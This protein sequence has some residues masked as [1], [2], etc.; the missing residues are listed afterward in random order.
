[1][2]ATKPRKQR[3]S[4]MSTLTRL[5]MQRRA[6]TRRITGVIWRAFSASVALIEFGLIASVSVACGVIYHAYAYEGPGEVLAYLTIGS[7]VALIFV[8]TNAFRGDYNI[9]EYI[10]GSSRVRRPFASWNIAFLY[11]LALSFAAKVGAEFSRGNVILLY[12]TGILTLVLWRAWLTRLVVFA[13]K[14]GQ[15]AARRVLLVG[16]RGAI[17]EFARRYQPWNLGFEIVGEAVLQ[18][19]QTF[20]RDLERAASIGRALHPD[21]VFILMPWSMTEMIERVVDKLLTVPVSIHLGPERIL[22][23]FARVEIVKV[24]SMATMCLVQPPLSGI[25]ILTKRAFDF[26]ASVVGLL[27]L[28]PLFAVVALAVKLESRGP[29]FFRQQRYG[30]NQKPF[31]IF[32][33]RTMAVHHDQVVRQAT[34]QDERVT[35]VGRHLRRWNIDELPQLINVLMG[36]MSL[37]GPRPHAV[38][39]NQSF[40]DRIDLYARRHNVKPGITGWAQVNGLRGETDTEEKMRRRVEFDLYYIDNWSLGFDFQILWRTLLSPKAYRNAY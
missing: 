5:Q 32:K 17:Q 20:D 27:L 28:V 11:A 14:T 29:V 30:F 40:E 35:R 9:R 39:H 21:D 12:S 37:V 24:S 1:M 4:S 16:E 34:P 15:I 25:G 33:F 13:S 23:R 7:V 8:S 22:D 19:S 10:S 2:V 6:G 36:Q 38:P 18:S 3:A 31:W 26:V